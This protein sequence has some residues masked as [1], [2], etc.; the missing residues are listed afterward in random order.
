MRVRDKMTPHPI[1]VTKEKSVRQA[2]RLIREK[3][4]RRLPVVEGKKLIGIVT[5]RDLRLA[6]PSPLQVEAIEELLQRFD[7]LKV[8]DI[9]RKDVIVVSPETPVEDAAWILISRKIGGLPV[10]S[11]EELVG[12]ITETDLLEALV[13]VL[14]IWATGSRVELVVEERPE[15]YNEVSRVVQERGGKVLD[16]VA[17]RVADQGRERPVLIV[18]V[19]TPELEELI[20]ALEEAGCLVLPPAL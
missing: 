19:K 8:Q 5:D 12:I 4:I 2:W 9:M 6:L 1:T 14:G 7:R 15:A 18:R 10:V 3:G 11:G 17:A 20:R 13:E 16:A